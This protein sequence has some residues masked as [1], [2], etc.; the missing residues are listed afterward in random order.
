[1]V[2]TPIISIQNDSQSN[3]YIGWNSREWAPSRSTIMGVT[4]FQ[5]GTAS[6]DSREALGAFGIIFKLWLIILEIE[7]G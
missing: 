3:I 5:F 6:R 4:I 2:P 7:I 1:M